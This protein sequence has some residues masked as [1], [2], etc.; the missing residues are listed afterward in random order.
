MHQNMVGKKESMVETAPAGLSLRLRIALS[1]LL[2]GHLM[3]VF[4]PPFTFATSSGPGIASPFAEPIMRGIRPYVELLYLDHGYF[5]FAPNP[6]PSHLLRAKLEFSDGRPSREL[7]F[8]DRQQQRPRL[9][10]H[11]HF[12]LAEQLHGDFVPPQVLP[13]IASDPEQLAR[14]QRARENYQRRRE[15]FENHLRVTH[16]ASH[17]VITRLEHT[18]VGPGEFQERRPALNAA[19]SY[20]ELLE[21]GMEVSR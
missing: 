11:R 9:L 1:I 7:T 17:A 5:F 8:P 15:S 18:L 19:E 12:M 2:V 10:Y 21:V 3:A 16:G 4:F 6:G 20:R 13:E 14:W